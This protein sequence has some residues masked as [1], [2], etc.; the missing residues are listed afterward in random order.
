MFVAVC[1]IIGYTTRHK[2]LLA[3]DYKFGSLRAVDLNTSKDTASQNPLGLRSRRRS[4]RENLVFFLIAVKVDQ[5][6]RGFF[7][8]TCFNMFNPTLRLPDLA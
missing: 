8:E 1:Y 6:C 3:A 5:C 4:E 7:A 2:L